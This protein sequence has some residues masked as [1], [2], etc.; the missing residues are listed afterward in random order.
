MTLYII[1]TNITP[2]LIGV[3]ETIGRFF[4]VD[5]IFLYIFSFLLTHLSIYTF[6]TL[7]SFPLSSFSGLQGAA[8]G[9]P[10]WP[11]VPNKQPNNT[12]GN[13]T[14]ADRHGSVQVSSLS[15]YVTSLPILIRSALIKCVFFSSFLILPIFFHRL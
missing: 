12:L 2:P 6:T 1:S 13:L 8:K 5:S 7:F 4:E 9:V 14:P 10:A 3:L 15:V 11:D